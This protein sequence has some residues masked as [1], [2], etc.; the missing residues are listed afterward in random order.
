V[1]I[2][3]RLLA[4]IESV[5]AKRPKTV[6]DHILR[7]GQITTQ[8][9]K[10]LYGYNHPPRAA[11]DV[12]E[13]G[14]AL[15]TTRVT[16][17]DGRRIAAYRLAMQSARRDP[18]GGRAVLSKRLKRRLLKRDGPRC[19]VC[20]REMEPRYL[21]IDHRVPYDIAGDKADPESHPE[22]FML[23]CGACNRA[24]SW[25]CEHCENRRGERPKVS[26]CRSCYWA[27][28][29]RYSHIANTPQ[30]QVILTWTGQK[31]IGDWRRL[32][33]AARA[34]GLSLPDYIL[35]RVTRERRS[36]RV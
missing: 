4:R 25:S 20:W 2:S 24:K 34:R 5:T 27:W 10:D 16:G 9:L 15:A 28:P 19:Q 30:R 33:K 31:G 13:Q 14:I 26:V 7:H 3:K 35:E 12:R 1:R 29:N 23:V 32:C 36:P 11:R 22:D 18:T 8:E 21:Q 17:P 6:L